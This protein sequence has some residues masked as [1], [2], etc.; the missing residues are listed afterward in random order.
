MERR[1]K[2]VP[3]WFPYTE[4]IEIK[5]TTI[6]YVYKGG[7]YTGDIKDAL[8]IMFYG[9]VCDLSNDFLQLCS[10][11]G[12]PLCIH[13]RNM[14]RAIWITPS[15]QTTAKD[16]VLTKQI[17][18]RSN[19]KKQEHI[20]KKLL[21]AKF[22][23][24]EWLIP[25][26]IRFDTRRYTVDEMR[27]IEAH[28]ARKYWKKYYELLGAQEFSRR[29]EKHAISNTLN[30]VSKL[31][32]GVILRYVIYHRLSPYHGFLH[33]PTDYP[34]LIY[35]L[36]EPYRGYIDKVVFDTILK[37]KEEGC[38]EKRYLGRC[39]VAIEDFFDESIYTD[40]TR[41]IVSFQELM[42]GVVLSLSSYLQGKSRQFVPPIPG[43]PNGGRP[44][45]LGYRLYG[46]SAGPTDFWEVAAERSEKHRK[47]MLLA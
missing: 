29:G 33:T 3:L 13:R 17:L 10:K 8:F 4:S 31:V 14:P 44:L 42:H 9:G 26:P 46:R 7:E 40:T 18:F 39:I 25:Y 16:D 22:K 43:V 5:K 34:A 15:V 47:Q 30:A 36:M 38:D 32:S 23:S 35:D 24:M 45:K 20:T 27:N 6:T 2:R 21:K 41:Q 37:A 28:H 11:Y 12:V 1:N 19:K